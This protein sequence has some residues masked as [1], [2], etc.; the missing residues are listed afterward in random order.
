MRLHMTRDNAQCSDCNGTG[1][2]VSSPF[3]GWTV[4][5]DCPTCN[6]SGRA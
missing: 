3:N 2:V 1:K 4:E 5:A 6:G